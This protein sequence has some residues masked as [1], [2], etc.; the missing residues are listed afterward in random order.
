MFLS[1]ASA[2]VLL[3]VV[4][5]PNAFLKTFTIVTSVGKCVF[6]GGGQDFGEVGGL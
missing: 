1:L 3:P 6:L 4:R 5:R 2:L